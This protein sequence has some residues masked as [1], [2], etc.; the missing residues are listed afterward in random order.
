MLT[1]YSDFIATNCP[2]LSLPQFKYL[3]P[4]PAGRNDEQQLNKVSD[5]L[6]GDGVNFMVDGYA[7]N[8]IF[9]GS[10]W[11]S[12]LL[13]HRFDLSGA[14]LRKRRFQELNLQS[15]HDGRIISEDRMI[16]VPRGLET[17]NKFI[18]LRTF[19][20]ERGEPS[21]INIAILAPDVPFGKRLDYIADAFLDHGKLGKH[22]VIVMHHEKELDDL[23]REAREA[24]MLDRTKQFFH[25]TK[26]EN[27]TS[28]K[29]QLM[30]WGEEDLVQTPF[31]DSFLADCRVIVGE[32]PPTGK[33]SPYRGL[34]KR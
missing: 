1:N 8:V 7:Q 23:N 2:N 29:D 6:I 22:T 18:A 13:A 34:E 10:H 24:R 9:L 28:L 27:D 17:I 20:T 26:W 33:E 32:L 5:L 30:D 19:L 31:Y 25:D 16:A 21:D 11:E 15:Q 4:I 12:L 14:D 3:I